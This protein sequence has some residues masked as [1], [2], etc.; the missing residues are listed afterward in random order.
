MVLE[1]QKIAT[2][3]SDGSVKTPGNEAQSI[4]QELLELEEQR[5][6]MDARRDYLESC[7]KLSMGKAEDLEGIALWRTQIRTL[8]DQSAL[9]RE[10]PETFGRYLKES[11]SRPFRL[12]K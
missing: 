12:K 7:L 2:E 1:A 9:K 11:K 5:T 4:Y 3:Y 8:L 10:E 6:K